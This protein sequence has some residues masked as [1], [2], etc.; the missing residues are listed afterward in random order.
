MFY[1]LILY[2]SR[3]IDIVNK[4]PPPGGVVAVE[5]VLMDSIK[6]DEIIRLFLNLPNTVLNSEETK[7]K[8]I[9]T[10]L[11]KYIQFDATATQH[12]QAPAP[13]PTGSGAAAPAPSPAPSPSQALDD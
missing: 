8:K 4:N 1:I 9:I 5:G 10:E 2:L 6:L 11:G 12:P 7:I 13:T 3:I